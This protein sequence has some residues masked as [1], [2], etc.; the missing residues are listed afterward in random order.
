[1]KAKLTTYIF[2]SLNLS[3]FLFLSTFLFAQQYNFINYTSNQGLAQS[4]VTSIIQD[5]N[6]YLWFSTFGGASR[7]DGKN[8]KNYSKE[9]GLINNQLFS[10]M[11]D[12]KGRIWFT[13]L[14]GFSYYE[15][16][17]IKSIRLSNE[18]ARLNVVGICEDKNGT[19]WIAIERAGV[20]SFKNNKLTY[21]VNNEIPM[22]VRSVYCDKDNKIWISTRDGLY[23]FENDKFVNFPINGDAEKNI[24]Y[25]INGKNGEIWI[26]TFDEGVYKFA[27]NKFTNYT[28][29]NGLISNWIRHI[30]IDKDGS[31]WF[32]AKNGVSKFY[33]GY[34]KNFTAKQGLINP[35]I[36]SVG[37]DMEGNI[38]L[39]TDGKGILRFSGEAFTNYTTSDGLPS[40]F[41]MSAVHGPN[42]EIWFSSYGKGVSRFKGE[43]FETFDEDAGLSNNTVWT[44]AFDGANLWFGTSY[45]LSVFD[46]K[47]FTNYF[48]EDGLLSD[49]I[50]SL[51]YE[52]GNLW[53]GSQDGLTLY[54]DGKFRNFSNNQGLT[55]TNI[56]SI[57]KDKNG[58]LWLGSSSGVYA[59]S[60][61]K[62]K[63]IPHDSP[64]N[65]NTVYC[66]NADVQGKIWIGTK[67]GLFYFDGKKFKKVEFTDRA[68]ANIVNFL[69][70]EDDL[71]W[72]GTNAS[73]FT[74]NTKKYINEDELIV[75]HFTKLEGIRGDE[76]NL[77]SAFKDK[78]GNYW[79]GTDGGLVRFDPNKRKNGINEIETFI[80]IES[81]KLFLENVDWKNY[82]K[83]IDS[84]KNIPKSLKVDYDENHFT[85][86]FQ[87]ICHSNP[88]EV[89]YQFKLEGFDPDWSPIT[90]AT[91]ATYSNLP[92]GTYTFMV[93]SRNDSGIWNKQ[94]ATF[95]FTITPPFWLTWW[96][97]ILCGLVIIF[98]VI[99]FYKWRISSINQKNK[100]QQLE[101]QSRLLALESQSLNASMNR[102]FIF[103]AL[104]SIQYYINKQDRLEANKY[105]TSFAKLIRKN[106][107]SS[108]SGNQV[109]L[110]EELERL[111]LYLSL[112][113]MRFKDKFA[114]SIELDD[115]VDSDSMKIP[116]MLLQP[117]VE[118]S[119]WHG[120]LPMERLGTIKI[121]IKLDG[122]ILKI[123]IIDDGI[124]ITTS[125]KNKE[126]SSHGHVSRGI[127]INS[128]R[129]ALLKQMT[130]ENM[131]IEGPMETFN[132][133]GNVTGTIVNLTI[134][135]VVDAKNE[136][137]NKKE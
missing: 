132:K 103:N 121:K 42:S 32:S 10:Q 67:N 129:L 63:N 26:S 53:I 70:R 101:Y 30:F 95:S 13:G 112:E 24:S 134:P 66:I 16:G 49:K 57:F 71:L 118:N 5:Q 124:G 127:Q 90:D 17:K 54:K 65:D 23:Y 119:I 114:Y 19:Y 9:D 122:R 15:K 91:F 7:F 80:H 78:K 120:I 11:I 52:N 128:G 4:Q 81:V 46:G 36:N 117:Y 110:T 33:Q 51:L 135:Q 6:G 82:T 64:E 28:E 35:N 73:I 58:I 98:S 111:E 131:S 109:S 105:L 130:N 69:I 31:V 104:N 2:K 50:T 21:Y 74:I 100:T 76:T 44:S 18:L 79:F 85:F 133:D 27:E 88:N 29:E 97:F 113:L 3:G 25:V 125:L 126:K 34:F 72:V 99:G 48:E 84:E 1:M 59:F 75:N 60:N 102:H 106:L 40:D 22:N 83:E 14:G 12:S 39:C 87:G 93:K 137:F 115:S 56:R 8:F 94:A 38:W 43:T 61:E 20:A 77:N 47:K 123:A 108:V 37:Q 96:F 55:G 92:P 45:G 89:R 107:D 68:N 136:V 41:I 86:Y 116:P 62:F